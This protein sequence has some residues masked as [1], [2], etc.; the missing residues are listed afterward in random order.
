MSPHITTDYLTKFEFARVLSLRILQ[1]EE[2]IQENEDPQRK[3]TREILE[4]KNEF[5]LRRFI[6]DGTYEDRKVKDLKI[7]IDIKRMCLAPEQ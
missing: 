4:G 5:V 7:G 6:S 1:L 2:T 3:A